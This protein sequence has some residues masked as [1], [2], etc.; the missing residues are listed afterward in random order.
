MRTY[1]ENKDADDDDVGFGCRKTG[2]VSEV[3]H[4]D[5]AHIPLPAAARAYISAS[6]SRHDGAAKCPLLYSR[7]TC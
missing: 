5:T 3:L 6:V 2:C 7:A 1:Y 4:Y